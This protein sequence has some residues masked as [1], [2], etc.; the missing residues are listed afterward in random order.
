[1]LFKSLVAF[2][3]SIKKLSLPFL[4][5]FN[6]IIMQTLEPSQTVVLNVQVKSA[7]LTSEWIPARIPTQTL[8]FGAVLVALKSH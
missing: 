7:Q 6:I 8:D 3:S 2:S 4:L 1:M 5:S